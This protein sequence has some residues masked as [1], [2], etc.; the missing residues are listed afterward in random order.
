MSGQIFISYRREE[1]RWSAGRL[2][3]RLGARF[4]RKQIFIDIDGIRPGADFVKTIEKKV[5]ECDVLVGVIGERWSIPRSPDLPDDLKPLVRRNALRVSDTGFDDD[6]RRLVTAIE[7]VLEQNAAELRERLRLETERIEKER[8]DAEQRE[9]DRVEAEQRE[10]Q[11]LDAEAREKRLD[12]E[13][14]EKQRLAAQKRE[15]EQVEAE[16][17]QRERLDTERREKERLAAESRQ[18]EE[19]ERRKAEQHLHKRLEQEPKAQALNSVASS[20]SR[21][22]PIEDEPSAETPEAVYPLPPKSS[23]PE[24]EKPP[25]SLQPIFIPNASQEPGAAAGPRVSPNWNQVKT[26]WFLPIALAVALTIGLGVVFLAMPKKPTA[27]ILM[28]MP[29]P[30]PTPTP[31]TITSDDQIRAENDKVF[32][33]LGVSLTPIIRDDQVRVGASPTPITPDDQIRAENE[34]VFKRL[35][36]SPTP[37]S[38]D[39]P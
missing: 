39:A 27:A 38:S 37:T 35:G 32:K 2:Y 24:R 12:A 28:P 23:E 30:T 19:E 11:R 26:K 17:R 5:G 31:T 15:K 36:V 34:K 33:R 21:A 13:Q 14:S 7:E 8:L 4:D 20:T 1:S 18:R 6:C 3:D 16:Q 22:K 9:K 29:T 10:K 25:E